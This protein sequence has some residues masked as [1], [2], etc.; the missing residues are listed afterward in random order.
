MKRRIACDWSTVRS[1][2]ALAIGVISIAWSAIF[3][4]WIPMPGTA[5]AFYRVCLATLALMPFLLFGRKR[6]MVC[7]THC[8]LLA[9]VGGLFFAGDLS[10][11]STAV[12]QTSIANA[13]VLANSSS[14]ILAFISWFRTGRS[15][16]PVLWLGLIATMMGSVLI[17]G[18]DFSKDLTF[19]RGDLLAMAA[20]VSFAA[21]LLVTERLRERVD[22]TTVLGFSLVGSTVFLLSFNVVSGTSLQVPNGR[23]WL[24]LVGLALVSQ[25][26]GYFALTYALSRFTALA[27]SVTLLLQAALTSLLALALIGEPIGYF[28]MLGGLLVF[29]G[30]FIVNRQNQNKRRSE[31]GIICPTFAGW[32][33]RNG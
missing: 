8:I 23:T 16:K 20:A 18:T 15:P 5:S 7:P 10:L 26:L 19:G 33:Q 9:S 25:L 21:Y 2:L 32:Q 12:Q 22:T 11:F 1:Y 28:Q 3:I 24:A 29:F 31:S 27:T 14:V 30:V 4:R 13:S 17:V 6:D